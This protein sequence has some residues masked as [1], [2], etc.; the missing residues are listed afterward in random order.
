MRNHEITLCNEQKRRFMYFFNKLNG[1]L[2]QKVIRVF[3]KNQ[4]VLPPK[5]AGSCLASYAECISTKI[6]AADLQ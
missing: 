5:S 2:R 1:M 4:G 3:Y 6:N